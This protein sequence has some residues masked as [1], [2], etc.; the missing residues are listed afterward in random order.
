[1]K[2]GLLTLSAHSTITRLQQ[3]NKQSPDISHGR[4]DGLADKM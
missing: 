2:A 4:A 1:M 3:M